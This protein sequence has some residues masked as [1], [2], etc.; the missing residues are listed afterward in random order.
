MF[1]ALDAL[2]KNRDLKQPYNHEREP[3]HPGKAK[4]GTPVA[5]AKQRGNQQH[6]GGRGEVGLHAVPE[7]THDGTQ[8]GGQVGPTYAHAGAYH[9]REGNAVFHAG[10]AGQVD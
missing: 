3:R 2:P 1:N 9:D 10:F 8:H 4:K 5:H 7:N 6:H